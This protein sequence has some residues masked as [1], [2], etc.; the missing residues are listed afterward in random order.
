MPKV[1]LSAQLIKNAKPR[2]KPYELRD[3]RLPGLILRVQPSGRKTFYCEY[4]RGKRVKVGLFSQ[5]SLSQVRERTQE[6][7]ADAYTG[8]D[9]AYVLRKRRQAI[10][11]QEFLEQHY[12]PW[13]DVNHSRPRQTRSMLF[14]SFSNFLPKK[15]SEITQA[16]AEKWRIQALKA[17]ASNNTI[18][19]KLGLFRASLN[20]AVEWDII[21]DSPLSKMKMLRSDGNEIVRYLTPRLCEIQT[22]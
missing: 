11:Y 8:G 13:A 1:S 3:T 21:A 19:R 17:S 22:P 4:T 20:K 16:S 6:I 2:E 14:N 18:N 9:P 12:L 7:L 5:I 15:V 10:S